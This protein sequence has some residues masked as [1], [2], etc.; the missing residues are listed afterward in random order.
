M[1]LA[2]HD[3]FREKQLKLSR[4]AAMYRLEMRKCKNATDY[5]LIY[6]DLRN[7]AE[8]ARL[9]FECS[10]TKYDD[11]RITASEWAEM[12]KSTPFGVLPVLKVNGR[13][14]SES[15]AINRYL[16]GALGFAGR[17]NFENAQIDAFADYFKDF[18]SAIRPY[19]YVAGGIR[20]GD[21]EELHK[22]IFLPAVELYFPKFCERLKATDGDFLFDFGVSWVDFDIA[23]C[24]LT[25]LG[26][27]SH[28]L[29]NYPELGR[30]VTAV[31]EIPTLKS[32]FERRPVRAI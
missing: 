30:M 7:L 13:A 24:L 11:V 27:D 2:R 3:A 17:N 16:A 14:I 12:K 18:R 4:R 22:K 29:D 6:F 26:F 8:S 9:M 21:V 25:L 32:Y 20:E 1:P 5:E 19:T 31:R 23:D 15:Q 10:G 28:L